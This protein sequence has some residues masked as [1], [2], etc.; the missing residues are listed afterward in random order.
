MSNWIVYSIGFLAQILFSGR[1]IVQWILSEKSKR[2]I[3]PSIFWEMLNKEGEFITPIENRFGVLVS[4]ESLNHFAQ[5]Y[6]NFKRKHIA[7]Y[8]MNP[9][10]PDSRTHKTRLYRELFIVTKE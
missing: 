8:D 10:G 9:K 3:T 6:P 4:E 2:I 5:T 1:L 7:R